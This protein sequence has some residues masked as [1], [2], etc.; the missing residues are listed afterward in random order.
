MDFKNY[1]EILGIT[2]TT[3]KAL[4]KNAYLAL[5][6]INHPDCGGDPEVFKL[7]SHA[8]KMLT[9]TIYAYKEEID[10]T[11]I[12]VDYELTLEQC[13]FGSRVTHH[14]HNRIFIQKE[15]STSTVITVL[16][17]IEP[18]TTILPFR[19]EFFNVDFGIV[20]RNVI[21]TYYYRENDRYKLFPDGGLIANEHVNILDILQGNSI[22]VE[23]LFGPLPVKIPALS[24]VG[25]IIEVLNHP[26]MKFRIRIAGYKLPTEQELKAWAE[27][28]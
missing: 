16:D 21:I 26:L 22:V 27:K 10:K 20:K 3:D 19:R 24:K 1:F 11:P 7:I 8:Y 2:P 6:K 13:A 14:I 25:T 23:S 4:I 17:E 18:G 28:K 9:D 15:E 12:K 5:S